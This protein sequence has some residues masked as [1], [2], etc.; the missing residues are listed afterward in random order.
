MFIN[1]NNLKEL[2]QADVIPPSLELDSA[3][4]VRGDNFS[5]NNEQIELYKLYHSEQNIDLR[6]ELAKRICELNKLYPVQEFWKDLTTQN[7]DGEEWR[8][9]NRWRK[10]YE[11]SSFGRIRCWYSYAN[12]AEIKLLQPRLIKQHFSKQEGYLL[13]GI[14]VKRKLTLPNKVNWLVANAFSD[15]TENLPQSNHI[16]GV[17]TN[18]NIINL[19]LC[20]RSYNMKHAFYCGL[21]P[22]Y[23]NDNHHQ[24][25][26]SKVEIQEVLSSKEDYSLLASKYAVSILTIRR[27]KMGE[28]YKHITKGIKNRIRREKLSPKIAL[29]IFN[30]KKKTMDLCAEYNT[31]EWVVQRIKSGE[32]FSKITGKKRN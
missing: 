16:D 7:L 1:E 21:R 23:D 13:C 30:S 10:H 19:E 27:V 11:A 28:T 8:L 22:F 31:T 29:E 14:N 17:K 12:G 5:M 32:T 15:N 9:I 18:N 20:T 25:K 2:P 24:R 4:S 6:L 3:A 26:L